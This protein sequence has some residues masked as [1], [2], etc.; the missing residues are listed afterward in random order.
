[1]NKRKLVFVGNGMAGVRCIEEILE[2]D[3]NR[4]DIT[5]F[6]SEPHPNYNRILLSSALAGDTDLRDIVLNDWDWY[7]EHHITLYAGHTVT[8]ID[9]D[10]QLLYTDTGIVQPYDDLVLATGSD[11]LMLPLQGAEKEGVIGFRNLQDC[12]TMMEAAGK[13]QK[14]VVIGG[15]LLGL[16]AARGLLNLGMDVQVVHIFA[17]LMERQLDP[18]AAKLL[19][20]ELEKQGMKF[21]MEK[22]S[23]EIIGAERVEG[24]RFKDGM[25]ISADLV[26]MAVGIRPNVALAKN[27]GIEVKR[28]GRRRRLYGDKR[29]ARLRSG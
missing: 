23:T 3:P 5:V 15:G 8:R 26:V 19:Q 7:E 10:K 25:E 6:G 16:E 2:L 17:N 24:L 18:V 21:L 1:M 13:Y 12:Q 22:E 4:F 28:G 14:A 11:P 27:S 20:S 9:S 29:E